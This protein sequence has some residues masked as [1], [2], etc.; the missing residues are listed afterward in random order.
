[1]LAGPDSEIDLGKAAL[2]IAKEVYPNLDIPAY[3]KQ[4]DNMVDEIKWL[5]YA[6]K[7]NIYDPEYKISA[8]NS[9]YYFKQKYEYDFND[10]LGQTNTNFFLNVI[11]DEKKGACFT[12]PLLYLCLADRAGIA[13]HGVNAP[14]HFFLRYDDGKYRSNI[15]VTGKAGINT[16][17]QYAEDFLISKDEIRLGVFLRTLSKKEVVSNMFEARGN[18]STR[19]KQTDHA[20]RDLKKAL[21]LNPLN[22]E[23]CLGLANIYAGLN[24]IANKEKYFNKAKELYFNFERDDTEWSLK[25]IKECIEKAK[26]K[27]ID[28]TDLEKARDKEIARLEKI[29]TKPKNK[30][31]LIDI[32]Q[33]NHAQDIMKANEENRKRMMN[34]PQPPAPQNPFP[35]TPTPPNPNPNK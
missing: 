24:D 29:K 17:G 35:Q 16:D 22:S 5:M 32:N 19:E 11:M 25:Y 20:I 8:I 18:Y 28:T 33:E 30:P 6:A 31:V 9:F 7:G 13:I 34:P 23:V 4:L 27:G 14:S 15:E 2:L 26:A 21:E 1:M 3:L 10:C 12:M